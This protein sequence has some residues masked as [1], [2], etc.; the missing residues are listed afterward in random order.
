MALKKLLLF[1]EVF[2][3]IEYNTK[4][5]L[6]YYLV[7]LNC[8]KNKY[9]ISIIVIVFAFQIVNAQHNFTT[10]KGFIPEIIS[11]YPS[12]RDLTISPSGTELYF[13]I[14]GYGGELSSI[15]CL[16]TNN[17]TYSKP[18]IASFSGQ[19]HDLEPFFSPD[20]LRLFFSSD[21]PL[22]NSESE[23]KDYDIWYVER[24][25]LKDD[26]S[27]PMNVGAPIN[28]KDN[29]FYPAITESNN[30]YFTCDGANSKGKDDIFMSRWKNAQYEIP[31]S[32]SDSVNSVGYEFNAYIAPDESYL[33][34]TCYNKEGG[35]GSGDLY[36]SFKNKN[37]EWSLSQNLGANINCNLMD[38]CPF[39]D[40]HRGILYFTSRRN[41]IKKQLDK[42]KTTTEI[43]KEMN[44]YE[45]GLSRLYQVDINY[46]LKNKS[47]K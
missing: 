40:T 26:W 43:L 21:R 14:Q 6:F 33:I 36:I 3:F 9:L 30:L 38:Y 20:G 22:N 35:L 24:K 45:N 37:N 10:V 8:M 29:E 41:F 31:V 46:L 47:V 42:R 5:F 23:L 19:Y 13:S 16:K 28:T 39:V 17:G 34:Y 2:C 4:L 1:A 32:L 27:K 44:I 11:Q 25:T 18:E 15:V 12:V 7:V